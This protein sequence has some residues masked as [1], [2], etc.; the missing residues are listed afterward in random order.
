MKVVMPST[1]YDLKG[2]MKAAILDDNP[3]MLLWHKAMFDVIEEIPEGIVPLGEACFRRTG[4]DL[5]LV[6]YSLM[7]HKAA[8]A[9]EKVSSEVSVEVIDLWTLNPLDLDTVLVSVR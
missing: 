7:A 9:A 6:S 4:L 8:E 3:V 2:L 5:T 1:I